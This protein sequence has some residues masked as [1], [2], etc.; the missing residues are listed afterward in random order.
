[1]ADGCSET[2]LTLFHVVRSMVFVRFAAIFTVE[3]HAPATAWTVVL[4]DGRFS[5][6]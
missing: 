6:S 1:M 5:V 3:L 4:D 2:W